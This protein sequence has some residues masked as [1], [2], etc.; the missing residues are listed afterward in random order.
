MAAL[1][2]L[3][4]AAALNAQSL[5]G[6]WQ[7]TLAAAG[8][9][10]RLVIH[11]AQRPTGEFQGTLD[12]PDQGARGIPLAGVAV[13][14]G[15][16]RF[17]VP[18]V[19]GTFEGTLNETRTTIDGAWTQGASLPLKLTRSEGAAAAAAAVRRPQTPQAPFS[20]REEL[21][22]YA[23]SAAGI[24]LAGTL[25]I[26]S[27]TGPF[28][29]VLLV[30]GSGPQD[31]D[32]TIL[33]HR[34]F[35]VIADG[36]TRRGIAVLRADDRGVGK[37]TG[38][39]A[40]AATSD[41]VTDAAAGIEYLRSRPEVDRRRIGI[42]GH[43]EGGLVGPLVASRDSGVAF[44]VLLAG[45]AVPGDE[46]LMQQVMA[47]GRAQGASDALLDAA[48]PRQRALFDLVKSDIDTAAL[49]AKLKEML[50][51]L[52]PDS[53]L[54]AQIAQATSPEY[55]SLLQSD[56]APALRA[57]R[58]PV[59]AIYGGKDLQVPG[60]ANAAAA[61]EALSANPRA[62]V[63]E[64]PG[65]NHLFQTANTG[66]PAEYGQIEETLAPAVLTRIGAWISAL[67]R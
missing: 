65:L 31:R 20:Y 53:Q 27:G 67:A 52:V 54:G 39:F 36:L 51:G 44:L 33:G 28:S 29:A 45:P 38:T 6:D 32:E 18:Q 66:L 22:S 57:L 49:T 63:V 17:T 10:L 21:V 47:I 61:R 48:M 30:T 13:E 42:L 56:P 9:N 5:A 1:L 19:G 14:N 12:S 43:S 41:F 62:E 60:D 40:T 34:P 16:V 11:L 50:T 46:L 37:S 24:A 4:A 35:L 26:P 23:N 3:G 59:L 25:T 15:R 55:R 58:I 8:V 7:G 64:F 2:C